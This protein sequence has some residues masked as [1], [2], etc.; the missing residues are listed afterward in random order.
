MMRLLHISDAVMSWNGYD[1]FPVATLPVEFHMPDIEI[2]TRIGCS[3][4]HLQ[5]YNAIMCEHRLDEAHMIMLFS[6]SLSGV[7]HHWFAT[8]DLSQCRTWND[9][10]QEFVRQYSFNTVMDVLWRELEA[11]IQRLDDSVTSFISHWR[12]KILQIIDRPSE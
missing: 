9:L 2:Y 5:L 4:I 10:A 7:V 3:R 1:D 8:L 6:L 12:E 11:L